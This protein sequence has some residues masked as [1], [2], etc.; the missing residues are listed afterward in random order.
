MS[1]TDPETEYEALM[2]VVNRLAARFPRI[3][4]DEIRDLT[5]GAFQDFDDAHVRDFVPVLVERTVRDRLRA[6][7]QD[8]A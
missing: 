7:S 6:R 5:A 2:H 3:D 1:S 8:A 4:E